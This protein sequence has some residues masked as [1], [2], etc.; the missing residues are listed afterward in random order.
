MDDEQFRSY[1]ARAKHPEALY[2]LIHDVTPGKT[3]A[4]WIAVC[5][6]SQIPCMPVVDIEDLP[7]DEHLLAVGMFEPHVHPTEGATRLVRS[8]IGFSRSPVSIRRHA[9]SFGEHSIEVLREAAFTESQ[10]EVLLASGAVLS[11]NVKE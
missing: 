4:E 11:P 2:G 5:E 3:T 9:P 7:A 6:A 1:G 8:P 10:I